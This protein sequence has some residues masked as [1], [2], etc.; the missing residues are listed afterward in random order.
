MPEITHFQQ[1]VAASIDYPRPDRLVSGNPQRTTWS[2]YE[3]ADHQLSCG[4]WACEVG[5]WRIQFADDKEEFFC[6]IEGQVCLW[7]EQGKGVIVKAGEAAVI[8]AG[9][10]GRFEVLEPVRKYF[11]VLDRSAAG[12]L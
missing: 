2:H 6:V 9:F 8:P 4:I 7:D 5:A 10:R 11:V 3:S 12:S 1:D